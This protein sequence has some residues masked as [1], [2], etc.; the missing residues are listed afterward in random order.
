[1]FYHYFGMLLNMFGAWLKIKNCGCQLFVY[2]KKKNS[3]LMVLSN[4]KATNCIT[5]ISDMQHIAFQAIINVVQF[6]MQYA[7]D[8]F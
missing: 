3:H 5:N 4:V 6:K 1:M 8:K 2:V 7:H